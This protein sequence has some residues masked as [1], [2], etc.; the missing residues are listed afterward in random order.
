MANKGKR[1]FTV[2]ITVGG[3]VLLS[4]LGL[5]LLTQPPRPLST[6]AAQTVAT[7]AREASSAVVQPVAATD[8]VAWINGNPL[9]LTALT[10]RQA[11]DRALNALLVIQAEDAATALD[12]LVNEVL[13]LSAAESAGFT[14]TSDTVA[15]EREALLDAYGKSRA[16]LEAELQAEGV[17]L[18]AFDAYLANL[19]TARDFSMAQAQARGITQ[20]AFILELRQANDVRFAAGDGAARAEAALPTAQ[21]EPTPTGIPPIETSPAP[22]DVAAADVPS[23]LTD[24]TPRG[25]AV[26]QRAPGFTLPILGNDPSATLDLDTLRG[27]PVVLSFWVTWC[28]HCRAQTP[29]LVEASTREAGAGIQFI[30]VNVRETADVVQPYLDKQ[31]IA[32]PV[33]LDSDGRT[34][35]HYQIT[36]FPTTYFLNAEGHVMARHV[37]QLNAQ[38]LEQYLALVR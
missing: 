35:Q 12:R 3:A 14:V 28:G 16:D 7:P 6:D 21:P 34:A 11:I 5:W 23:I 17:S 25:T 38:A 1:S 2:L 13:L 24:D 15:T 26:G 27:Q 29:L 22:T 31:G 8:A 19:I 32:Y 20:E 33:V 18:V 4:G 30:G 37:G 9:P 10:Q 36:G